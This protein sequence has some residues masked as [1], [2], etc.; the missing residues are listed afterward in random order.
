MSALKKIISEAK[1]IRAKQ[2]GKS[3]KACVKAAGAKYRGGSLPGARKKK[4]VTKKAAV[5]KRKR[6]GSVG[7]VQVAANVGNVVS[8]SAIRS[9]YNVQ[10]K[11]L[12]FRKDQAKKVSDK[13][14]ISKQITGVRRVLNV[15]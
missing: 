13:K 5:K 6:V 1:R 3:W 12:L 4:R 10:L 15:L 9:H 14:K 11:D 8:K 2:P 7:K